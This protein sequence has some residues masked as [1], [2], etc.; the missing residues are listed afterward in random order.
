MLNLA[1][2]GREQMVSGMLQRTGDILQE[3]RIV[4]RIE[5]RAAAACRMLLMRKRRF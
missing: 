5:E 3:G 4:R 2:R 1:L